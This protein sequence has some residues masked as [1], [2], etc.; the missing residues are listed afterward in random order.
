[1]ENDV[2][3]GMGAVVMNGARI[4][5]HSIVGVGAVVTEGTEVPPGSVVLGI[6]ARVKRPASENDLARIRLAAEH[7]VENARR[8]LGGE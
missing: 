3:I 6:P 2:L 4:G 5:R 1:V 7:Y 8:Y